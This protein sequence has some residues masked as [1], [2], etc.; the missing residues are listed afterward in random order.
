MCWAVAS[1]GFYGL[2]YA[3]G[4]LSKHTYT[5]LVMMGVVDIVGYA[6]PGILVELMGAHELQ[7]ASFVGAWAALTGCAFS[8]HGSMV[9][10]TCALLG[11]LFLDFAFTTVFLLLL[12]CFAAD[13][14][15]TMC[16]VANC[17][18]RLC[19]L[20]TP[21]LMLMPVTQALLLIAAF[22]LIGA[23]ATWTLPKA[24]KAKS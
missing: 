23:V 13:C 3:C 24:E 17:F 9:M 5:N 16:G 18:A 8:E 1:V 15:G 7:I 6:P 12:E 20:I 2:T 4:S 22:C 19:T 21:L 10:I 11:R 14:R